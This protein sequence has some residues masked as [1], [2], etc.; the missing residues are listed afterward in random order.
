MRRIFCDV[1]FRDMTQREL[2][3]LRLWQLITRSVMRFRGRFRL[4]AVVKQR[5]AAVPFLVSYAIRPSRQCGFRFDVVESEDFNREVRSTHRRKRVR[6]AD[7][8][9]RSRTNSIFE[10]EPVSHWTIA[11]GRI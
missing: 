4:P 3:G 7:R 2:N 1:L 10:R 9:R 6:V 11:V 5:Y 8:L